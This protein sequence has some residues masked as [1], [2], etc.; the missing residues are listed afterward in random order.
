VGCSSSPPVA[1]A[2]KRR[3]R[4]MGWCDKRNSA[5]KSSIKAKAQ[6]L[7]PDRPGT[8]AMDAHIAG[9]YVLVYAAIPRHETSLRKEKAQ[10]CAIVKST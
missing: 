9:Y 4:Q 6:K 10:R 8:P 5:A 3:P 7:R 1:V 2:A